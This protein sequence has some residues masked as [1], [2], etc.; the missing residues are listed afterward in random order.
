LIEFLADDK[1]IDIVGRLDARRF[2]QGFPKRIVQIG[3]K[4]YAGY[5]LDGKDQDYLDHWRKKNDQL[6]L[7][8]F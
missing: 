7:A 4:K 1:A 3:Y 6:K 2:L 8:V 5:Q